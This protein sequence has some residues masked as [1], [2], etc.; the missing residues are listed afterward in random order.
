MQKI[1]N[2]LLISFLLVGLSGCGKK[3][4]GI[5]GPQENKQDATITRVSLPT[6]ETDTDVFFDE[7]V[8]EFDLA[9]Q[10]SF[11]GNEY[12]WITD[13]E[14]EQGFK[15]IYFDFDGHTLRADQ[16]ERLA[17]NVE[18]IKKEYAHSKRCKQK[19]VVIV[20]GHAC[21]SAGSSV[22]NVAKSEK[23]AKAVYDRL[24]AAG[25]PSNSIKIVGRGKE[26]PE[27][28]QG[29]IVLGDRKQ[30]WPNRRDEIK[31]VYS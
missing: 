19:P 15:P 22:Y 16:Q 18:R 27:V 17:W 25:V 24:V 6:S 5:V 29:K 4:G 12:A 3:K 10:T 21:H 13:A 7:S 2:V 1:Y 26:V 9:Q 28:I 30:Q 14:Q 8:N 23:R 11:E 20:E 31:V